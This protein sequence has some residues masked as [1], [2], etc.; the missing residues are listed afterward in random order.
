M[1]RRKNDKVKNLRKEKNRGKEDAERKKKV[2]IE[3][4]GER[5]MAEVEE[6]R[7]GFESGIKSGL[8]S[9]CA[10]EPSWWI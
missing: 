7:Q 6:W 10:V 1:I 9:R 4:V 5:E 3:N 2:R 8:A